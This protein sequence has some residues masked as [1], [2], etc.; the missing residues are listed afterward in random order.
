MVG[1]NAK[2]RRWGVIPG[3]GSN[4]LRGKELDIKKYETLPT[5]FTVKEKQLGESELHF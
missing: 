3:I 5:Y 4:G 1:Q 2:V